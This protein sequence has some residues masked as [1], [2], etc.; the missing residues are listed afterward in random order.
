MSL[1]CLA[2]VLVLSC[3][4]PAPADDLQGPPE[5]VGLF[6]EVVR[7]YRSTPVYRDQGRFEVKARLG[8]ETRTFTSPM[9][10]TLT[11]PNRLAV[12]AGDV[13]F[14][15]DGKELRTVVTAS[16][17]YLAGPCPERVRAA[18]L[19]EGP[20]GAKVLGGPA[21][22]PGR[23]LLALLL[24]ED[25]SP[26][27]FTDIRTIARE[28]DRQDEGKTL[29]VL[30]LEM[31]AGPAL[32]LS[33][34]SATRF[35]TAI[36][37]ATT[38]EALKEKAPA[39]S[40]LTEA[41]IGWRSGAVS[42]E[43]APEGS[44][45]LEAPKGVKRVEAVRVPPEAAGDEKAKGKAHALVDKEAPELSFVLLDGP[46]K[47]KPVNK[48]D[49]KGKVVVLDF[50][51]TWCGPCLAKLPELSELMKKYE[52][53]AD[54]AIIALNIEGRDDQPEALRAKVEATLKERGPEVLA[55]GQIGLDT[56]MAV[57]AAFQVNAIPT[58][59]ILDAKGVVRSY[60]VGG[61]TLAELVAEV[62]ALRK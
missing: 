24:D 2:T 51:A 53:T 10:I 7:A 44:F 55:K 17:Q 6:R 34:D 41:A 4:D 45:Q 49:L 58:V 47:T 26:R 11:R 46:G 38:P 36:D 30:R 61:G 20:L 28:A 54:V 5:A 21:A 62:E 8:D 59:V 25:D 27:A 40:G 50:W 60:R 9:A 56:R 32:I 14:A 57:A 39:G 29:Q 15:A 12:D 33:I 31:N 18:D 3:P 23:L 13:H 1:I 48:D 52:S 35:L 22:G 19:T 16:R 43:P 42:T 37:L